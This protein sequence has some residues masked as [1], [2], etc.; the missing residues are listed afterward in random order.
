MNAIRIQRLSKSYSDN[1]KAV[2]ALREIDLALDAG[3]LTVL[4]GPPGSGKTTLLRILAGLEKPSRGKVIFPFS[5]TQRSS[6]IGMVFNEPRL[7][8]WLTVAENIQLAKENDDPE[9]V[10]RIIDTIG[11]TGL[12]DTYPRQL[13]GSMAVRAALGR[14]LYQNP[15]IILMDEPFASLD[16]LSCVTL[17]EDLVQLFLK[18]KKTILFA[19]HDVEEA[20]MLGEQLLIMN[21]GQI[22]ADYP[23]PTEFPRKRY[24]DLVNII[25]RNLLGILQMVQ[26]RNYS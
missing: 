1:G 14:V 23:L 7:L 13:S 21:A 16:Y 18:E 6:K 22:A 17:Q 24:S 12:E 25:K 20:A 5:E 15:D 2:Q 8:P 9:E 10:Q 19:T 4:V 11:L 3:T 26:Q